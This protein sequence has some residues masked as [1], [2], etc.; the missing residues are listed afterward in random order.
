MDWLL[1]TGLFIYGLGAFIQ[2]WEEWGARG[3]TDTSFKSL[4]LLCL[5]PALIAFYA[6]KLDNPAI[7]IVTVLPAITAAIMFLAK[8]V[9]LF[10][11][12][13]L[14]RTEVKLKD[15]FRKLIDG[16]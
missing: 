2:I 13:I 6:F 9:D 16:I 11:T 1:P 7:S 15:L 14:R 10:L 8:L 5:G 3:L 12:R 4:F